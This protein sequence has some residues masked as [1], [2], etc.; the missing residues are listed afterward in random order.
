MYRYSADTHVLLSEYLPTCITAPQYMYTPTC[1]RI[2]LSYVCVPEPSRII[3]FRPLEGVEKKYI[4]KVIPQQELLMSVCL[5]LSFLLFTVFNIFFQFF[6]QSPPH[7]LLCSYLRY[8][9]YNH[10]C[11]HIGKQKIAT[12]LAITCLLS[13]EAP[14]VSLNDSRHFSRPT[15]TCT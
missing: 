8:H 2:H 5:S 9:L 3:L 13:K 4:K 1:I 6:Y 11:T 7:S 15:V 10:T 14:S 12:D